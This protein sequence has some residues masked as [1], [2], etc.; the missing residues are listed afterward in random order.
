MKD[1]LRVLL[2]VLVVFIIYSLIAKSYYSLLLLVNI[3]SLVVIYFALE[4]GE[5]TGA[6]LGTFFG[7]IQDSFSLGVFG[8]SGIAKTVMGFLAGYISRKINVTP[9]IKNFVFIFV[10]ISLELVIWTGLYAL[11]FLEKVNTEN[12]LFFFQ[13]VMT[14]LLG[15]VS[16]RFI[17]KRRREIV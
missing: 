10:L 14:A 3:F 11:I 6:C 17:R 13:P 9:F 8:V 16:Y 2:V 15:S 12:G 5:I 7:L 1:F 4:K